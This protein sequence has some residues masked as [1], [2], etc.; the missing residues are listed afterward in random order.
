M[1]P[2][3]IPGTPFDAMICAFCKHFSGK[4]FNGKYICNVFPE[5]LPNDIDEG[6][7]DH[8]QPHPGDNGMQFELKEDWE[9]PD[10]IDE[11]YQKRE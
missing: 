1:T 11:Y 6:D 7:F 5:G 3:R 4:T 8:R 2:Q 10:W 9:L